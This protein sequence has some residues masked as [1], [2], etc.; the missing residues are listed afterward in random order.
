M[1]R[2]LFE[3]V[4]K[5]K[6]FRKMILASVLALTAFTFS[7]A[8]K[9]VTVDDVC[10]SL[11][12]HA[13]TTG[14]FVQEKK[15]ASIKR[16][17]KSYGTYIFTKE[18]IVW[19]TTKPFK[20]TMVITPTSIVQTQADGTSSVIDSSTSQIFGT[21]AEMFSALFGGNRAALEKHFEIKTVNDASGWKLILTPKDATIA[22]A[23]KQFTLAGTANG[24]TV[25]LESLLIEESG[26]DSILYT[27]S[28]QVYKETLTNEE[29]A[30]FT[31][32]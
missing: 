27:F 12:K 3:E 26:T 13:V 7:A 20:T 19:N 24:N 21:I 16:P 22:S 17:L 32:K 23:M 4:N 18:G 5:M 11:T 15:S 8:A 28:D 31:S 9:E 14:N 10:A 6:I 1:I 30:Y 2:N 29:K 25:Q